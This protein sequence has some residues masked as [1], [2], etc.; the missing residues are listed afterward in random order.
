MA[1]GEKN[2]WS[3][4]TEEIVLEIRRMAADGIL[5]TEISRAL[6][7]KPPTV[8]AVVNRRNWKHIIP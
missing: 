2:G 3:I 8:S 4:L 7:V 6:G 5:Q 1:R